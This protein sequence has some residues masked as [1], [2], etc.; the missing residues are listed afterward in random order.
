[1]ATLTDFTDYDSVRAVLGIAPE[2]LEDATL[3]LP[4]F[5]IRLSEDIRDL[6]VT[7]EADYLAA[8]TI[9]SPA[10]DETRFINLM[11]AYSAYRVAAYELGPLPLVAFKTL[12]DQAAEA[13]RVSNPFKEIA[14][15]VISSLNYIQG[16]LLAA[17]GVISPGNPA[18]TPTARVWVSGV[19]LAVDPV[20]G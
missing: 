2:E 1:M 10:A 20:T 4:I 15:D 17:Y 18:P 9:I 12:K 14:E 3:A 13:D 8:K 5:Y 6:S 19:G 11:S 16:K 7:M